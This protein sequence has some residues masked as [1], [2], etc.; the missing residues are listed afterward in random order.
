MDCIFCKIIKKEIPA[1]VIYEDDDVIAFK[2]INPIAPVHVL[3]I[4]KHHF[5]SVVEI[6]EGDIAVM[7][8]LV[9]VAKKI[10]EDLKI[11]DGG[12]KLLIRVGKNGGQEV[13]H[14]H[15]HL[16]GGARLSENI[17]PV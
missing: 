9:W 6:N 13:I 3:I 4:P 1:N 14:L 5:V 15:M 10:A 17:H 7:G 11:S 2:D 8:K 16:V 12:Y